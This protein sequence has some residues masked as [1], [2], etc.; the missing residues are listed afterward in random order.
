MGFSDM[1]YIDPA[2]SA[3]D[4]HAEEVEQ[5]AKAKLAAGIQARLRANVNPGIDLSSARRAQSIRV[6]E[7]G[8][9]IVIDE[10]DQAAVLSGGAPRRQSRVQPQAEGIESLFKPSSGVPV[11]KREPDGST[12]LVFRTISAGQLFGQQRQF[13]QDRMV[14]ATV[15]ETLRMGL[16]DAFEA[17]GSEIESMYPEDEVS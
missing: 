2:P 12:R 6:A 13:E 11:A 10:S 5:R 9:S 3:L 1:I 17:A 14:E 16:V 4:R 7:R 8:G 15:T